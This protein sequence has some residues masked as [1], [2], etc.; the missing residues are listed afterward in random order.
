[1]L[2]I[3]FEKENEL[4]DF[5][6]RYDDGE[7]RLFIEKLSGTIETGAWDRIMSLDGKTVLYNCCSNDLLTVFAD[8]ICKQYPRI[9]VEIYARH[10]AHDEAFQGHGE[11]GIYTECKATIQDMDWLDAQYASYGLFDYEMF[12]QDGFSFSANAYA[13]TL[14]I[15]ACQT[16][17]PAQLNLPATWE[18]CGRIYQL[19][20]I[21]M[22]AFR[23]CQTLVSVT[24]PDTVTDIDHAAF[25]FCTE[26]KDV[27]IP[28]SV[29][30]FGEYAFA[31]CPHLSIHIDKNNIRIQDLQDEYGDII[32]AE[33]F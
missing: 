7:G 11:R 24:I 27:Y 20:S 6:H 32:I 2:L 4:Y 12:E 10:M 21:G 22:S 26:L 30:C 3:H 28:K 8:D 17:P 9:I 13:R 14:S 19:T 33:D 29:T 15:E 23:E 25:A 1:M 5:I 16:P 31:D 18:I